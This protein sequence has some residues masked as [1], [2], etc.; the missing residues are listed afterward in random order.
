MI[1]VY[2]DEFDFDDYSRDE[3]VEV[4]IRQD[5]YIK[6]LENKIEK[7]EK[8]KSNKINEDFNKNKETIS[9]I[10]NTILGDEKL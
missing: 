10:F 2:L 7:M 8:E 5:D 9:Q 6:E 4:I 1:K 3:L